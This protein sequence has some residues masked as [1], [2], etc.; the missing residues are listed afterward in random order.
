[1]EAPRKAAAPMNT[2][3]TR[4]D[5]GQISDHTS[6]V[7]PPRAAPSA[8]PGLRVPPQA[9]ALT[10][11]SVVTA[12]ATSSRTISPSACGPTSATWF[13]TVCVTGCPLPS[14]H[15]TQMETAPTTANPRGMTHSSRVVVGRFCS[16]RVTASPKSAPARPIAGPHSTAH[17][18]S[19]GEETSSGIL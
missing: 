18:T 11:I 17:A 3:A 4:L 6:P 2:Q 12:L 5:P 15:G 1:M 13:V 10:V 9:P 14:T 16:A 19:A 7:I 8:I